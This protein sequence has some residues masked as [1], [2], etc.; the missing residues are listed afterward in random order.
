MNNI[1]E[2]ITLD[3][4]GFINESLCLELTAPIHAPKQ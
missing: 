2:E 3:F 4:K 1:S